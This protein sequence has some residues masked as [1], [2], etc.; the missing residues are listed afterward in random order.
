MTMTIQFD[1][2]IFFWR[3]PAPHFFVTIPPSESREIKSIS[4]RVTYGWGVIP[5][6]VRIGKT[7]WMTSLIP[8]DGLYLVPIRANVRKAE[9]LEEGD[10][11]AVQ[12]EISE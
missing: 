3:G 4:N 11:V 12:V 10:T 6:Q 8:K 7:T 1:E 9:K 5:V 2:T